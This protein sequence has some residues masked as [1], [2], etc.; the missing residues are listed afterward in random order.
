MRP[1][2]LIRDGSAAARGG[3]TLMVSL[4]YGHRALPLAWRVVEGVK[5]HFPAEMHVALLREVKARVPETAPVTFLG[6]GEFDSPEL[7]AEA[8]GYGWAYVCRTAKNIQINEDGKWSSLEDSNVAAGNG[9]FAK[10]S[11]SPR[12]PTAR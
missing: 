9:P 7:Q 4:L 1:L 10:A 2:V 6:D 11:C 5:G 8:D 12:P 3:V